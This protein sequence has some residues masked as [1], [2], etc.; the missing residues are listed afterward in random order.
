M[1]SERERLLREIDSCQREIVDRCFSRT[2]SAADLPLADRYVKILR[3][4]AKLD[5]QQLL[6]LEFL[7]TTPETGLATAGTYPG[8]GLLLFRR[9]ADASGFGLAVADLRGRLTYA[10]PAL[11]RM[12]GLPGPDEAIGKNLFEFYSPDTQATL[13]DRII[14][15]VL[16]EGQWTGELSLRHARGEAI[17]THQNFFLVRGEADGKPYLAN[18]LI[19]ITQRRRIEDALRASEERFRAVFENSAI[20]IYRMAPSGRVLMANPALLRMLGFSTFAEIEDLD[21]G[22]FASLESRA[23]FLRRMELGGELRGHEAVWLRHD[24]TP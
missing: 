23:E 6:H 24:G 17:A 22:D 16:D 21:F 13:R 19:D 2:E 3:A 5:R 7:G 18:L 10:N 4:L 8:S 15:K 11:R 1:E 20:G 12:V 9:L 14:P